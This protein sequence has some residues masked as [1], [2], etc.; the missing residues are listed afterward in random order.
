MDVRTFE[1]HNMKDALKAV[2]KTFGSDAVILKTENVN[3]PDGAHSRLIKI[4]ATRSSEEKQ[5]GARAFDTAGAAP[6][7]EVL[8][9]LGELSER[10]TTL[11][12]RM[13]G[14]DQVEMLEY[15]IDELKLMMSQDLK[16]GQKSGA[17]SSSQAVNEILRQLRMTNIEENYLLE[18]A[19]YLENLPGH[20]KTEDGRD[21]IEGEKE[22]LQN[23][24]IK[25]VLKRVKIASPW[26][27]V[28]GS[29]SIHAFVGATGVGKTSMVARL[30]SHFAN[31]MHNKVLVISLDSHRVA[32][33]EQ[34]R[35]LC[36]AMGVAYE[37]IDTLDQLEATIE[38]H[39]EPE[40][41]LIDTAGRSTK[42]KKH[43][44]ELLKFQS[45]HLPVQKH[46]VLS[47]SEKQVQM[48]RSVRYFSELG[49]NSLVFSKLDQTWS[50]GEM[51]NVISRWSLPTSYFAVDQKIPGG[52]ERASRERVVER[53]FGL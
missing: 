15:S 50:Y 33:T 28:T 25:W 48:D 47:M 24:A 14:K 8:S 7:S 41:V 26:N 35:V 2:K 29:V 9:V 44:E 40:L 23:A 20:G 12:E 17:S 31:N 49:I 4:T 13:I 22:Y 19:S 16:S 39:D 51:F 5:V 34:L 18:L 30:A 42:S 38:K 11:E 32:A 53:I 36:K 37:S 45:L 46:L 52:F 21:K 43:I 3:N 6:S 27:V 10:L 1:A